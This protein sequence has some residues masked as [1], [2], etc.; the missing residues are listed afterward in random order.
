MEDIKI[1]EKSLT[2]RITIPA[3]SNEYWYGGCVMDGP[4]Y[5]FSV[6]SGYTL[7]MITLEVLLQSFK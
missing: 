4:Q 5:P 7:E 3:V 1:L 2:E 6:E